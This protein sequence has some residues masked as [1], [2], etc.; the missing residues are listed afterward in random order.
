MIKSKYLVL[1]FLAFTFA[2]TG[3]FEDLQTT[4]SSIG[5]LAGEWYVTNKIDGGDVF[6]DGYQTITTTN[7]A[8][9][10]NTEMW[11]DDHNHHYWFRAKV[12]LN[13]GSQ[14]FA[15]DTFLSSVIDPN[16]DLYEVEMNV[17]N[18]QIISGAGLTRSGKATDSIYFEA[19][20]ADW[21]TDT[22]VFSGHRRSG[23]PEDEF[24]E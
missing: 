22:F 7:T 4:Q 21:G 6:G 9:D 5:D 20:F 12:N 1:T 16:D 15:V 19:Q 14:T 18:G 13:S 24:G 8:A 2:L 17:F 3:C 11:I 10:V 23:L